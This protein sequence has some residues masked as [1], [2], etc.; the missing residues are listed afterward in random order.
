MALI[1]SV[2]VWATPTQAQ[3]SNQPPTAIALLRTATATDSA[4]TGVAAGDLI[5]DGSFSFDPD[6]NVPAEPCGVASPDATANPP[7]AGLCTYKWEVV[8]STYQWLGGFISDDTAETAYVDLGAGTPNAINLVSL[9]PSNGAIIEFRLT[10]TDARGASDTAT[11]THNIMTTEGPTA[12]IVVTSMLADPEGPPL[13]SRDADDDDAVTAAEAAAYVAALYTVDAVIDGPGENGNADNEYDIKENSLLMLDASGSTDPDDPQAL[14]YAWALTFESGLTGDG[15]FP[16]PTTGET[17]PTAS[18]SGTLVTYPV[19]ADNTKV[20]TNNPANDAGS[21]TAPATFSSLVETVGR[22]NVGVR[23]QSP[24]YAIYTLTVTDGQGN[25]DSASVRIAIWDQPADPTVSIGIL[26]DS[27]ATPDVD[28]D[29]TSPPAG[30]A[31]RLG[32]QGTLPPGN[33]RYVIHKDATPT[34][35]FTVYDADFDTDGNSALSSAENTNAAGQPNVTATWSGDLKDSDA[36]TGGFQVAIPATAKDGDSFT[37]TATI[38]RTEISDSVTFVVQDDNTRPVATVLS[39]AAA[40]QT[41]AATGATIRTPT[42]ENGVYTVNGFG[43]DPDGGSVTTVWTQLINGKAA[44]PDHD[45][46]VALTGAFSNAVSFSKPTNPKQR[47]VL[48][49]LAVIDQHGAFQIQ[50]VQINVAADPLAP[51][52]ASAG[53]DQV[54][55]P[56]STVIL[57]GSVSGELGEGNNVSTYAWTVTDLKTSPDPGMFNKTQSAAVHKSLNRFFV[58]LFPDGALNGI[59]D[60]ADDVDA[61]TDDRYVQFGDTNADGDSGV[62][63]LKPISGPDSPTATDQGQFQYFTAPELAEGIDYAQI[64][65]TL[66]A[67]L[68]TEVDHDRNPDTPAVTALPVAKAKIT[69]SDTFFSSYIDGPDYCYNKS[70]GGP[71]TRPHDS[72]GDGVADVCSLPY[73]RREAVARQNALEQLASL[74][75]TINVTDNNSSAGGGAVDRTSPA[76]LLELMRGRNGSDAVGTPGTDGYQAAVS[77]IVGT[78][79]TAKAL[80]LRADDPDACD[81]KYDAEVPTPLP[82]PVDPANAAMFYSGV[83]TG[84]DFCANLSLGGARTFAHDSDVPPDGVADVCSLHTTRREAVA[85]QLALEKFGDP[86]NPHPQFENAFKAACA[87]LGSETFGESAAALDADAC[88]VGLSPPRRDPGTRLP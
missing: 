77:T 29:S 76:T 23:N 88:E 1:A 78:C 75:L 85:R 49:S 53:G 80:D 57:T 44:E 9:V 61:T 32:L 47:S 3:G 18:A 30:L 79:S 48:L 73:T 62:W 71:V 43:F 15:R 45:D 28:T 63:P 82:D 26:N 74:N 64:E 51:V 22:L 58:D 19:G 7:Q 37:V 14:T 69:V 13:A 67:T 34:L 68:T 84:P 81:D 21:V 40:D 36:I 56:D 46:Y 39:P 4:P 31:P 50:L 87:A 20:S 2:L 12:D 24:Y 66:L 25:S 27:P 8:T 65:F 33:G 86:D 59:F 41:G 54:V 11:V 60:P 5:L 55:A 38:P 42:V 16:L 70:L 10:V 35:N 83:I 72:N 52:V 17:R 6:D